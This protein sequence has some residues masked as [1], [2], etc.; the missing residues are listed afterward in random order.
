MGELE[1]QL[2]GYQKNSDKLKEM[3]GVAKGIRKNVRE[4]EAAIMN[5]LDKA[6]KT[7]EDYN[8]FTYAKTLQKRKGGLVKEVMVNWANQVIGK[9]RADKG[10]NA[11]MALDMLDVMRVAR[12]REEYILK[13]TK[14][15]EAEEGKK[16]SDDE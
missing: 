6:K 9:A 5:M 8:G 11:E 7:S 3:M 12:A 4:K 13:V 15:K 1:T 14:K 16:G 10:F 2:D